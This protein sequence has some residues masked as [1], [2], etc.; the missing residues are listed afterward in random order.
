MTRRKTKKLI[1]S[2]SLAR[3]LKALSIASAHAAAA[4]LALAT[5]I[6]SFRVGRR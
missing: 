5:A 1:K 4:T 2:G 3:R 6:D